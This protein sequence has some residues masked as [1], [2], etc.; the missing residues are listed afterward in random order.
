MQTLGPYLQRPTQQAWGPKN[1]LFHQA[2]L[3]LHSQSI[4]LGC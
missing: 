3:C 2:P 1:L 4:S